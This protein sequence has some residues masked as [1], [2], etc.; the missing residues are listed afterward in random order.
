MSWLNNSIEAVARLRA[1]RAL[2]RAE[3]EAD[4]QV[5]LGQK[6]RSGAL[7]ELR[8]QEQS[9]GDDRDARRRIQAIRDAVFRLSPR[10]PK[11]DTATRMLYRDL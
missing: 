9:V 10:P 11:A 3:I 8:E 5:L 2:D 4:A 1:A 6:S 7:W